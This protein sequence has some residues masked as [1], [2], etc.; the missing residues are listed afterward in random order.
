MISTNGDKDCAGDIAA[1]FDD[2]AADDEIAEGITTAD[3]CACA[4]SSSSSLSSDINTSSLLVCRL[5][6]MED[7][8]LALLPAAGSTRVVQEWNWEITSD[9]ITSRGSNVSVVD[10]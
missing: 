9:H 6:G 10:E 8:A 1:D 7:N 2:A 5:E 3:V 4:L